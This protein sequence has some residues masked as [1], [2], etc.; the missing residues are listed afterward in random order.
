MS[1]CSS[2]SQA[3]N[4]AVYVEFRSSDEEVAKPLKVKKQSQDFQILMKHSL[5]RKLLEFSFLL[6]FF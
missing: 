2:C 6:T 5:K 3:R 4:I 1:H